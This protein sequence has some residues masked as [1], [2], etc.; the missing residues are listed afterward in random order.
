MNFQLNNSVSHKQIKNITLKKIK[1]SG[2]VPPKSAF[3]G[4][5][6]A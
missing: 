6:N 5:G 2:L 1:A 3:I 4:P